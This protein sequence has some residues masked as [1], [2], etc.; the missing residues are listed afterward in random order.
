MEIVHDT[1]SPYYH[2]A[3][4]QVERTNQTVEA[5]LKKSRNQFELTN[6]LNTYYD[7]PIS[8]LLPSPAELFFNRWLNTCL[9]LMYQPS[10]LDELQKSQ[11]AERCGAH[12][13][14]AKNKQQY[15]LNQ[16]IWFTE[17]G[18]AE[19]RPG[20]I[21]S[22]DPHPDS[23]WIFNPETKQRVRRNTHNIKARHNNI[24]EQREQ[25]PAATSILEHRRHSL[26]SA[27]CSSRDLYH[28]QEECLISEEGSPTINSQKG[29]TISQRD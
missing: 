12:L 16:P 11:L 27:T 5:F 7:T 20:Y 26:P 23:Y 3:L 17:D 29:K 22:Q 21:E 1:T 28:H 24:T 14:P 15:V 6:C 8:E 13:K 18:C 25:P 19:W 10:S 2:E 9:G 4:G